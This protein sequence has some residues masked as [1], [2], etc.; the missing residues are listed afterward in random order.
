MA[1]L[2]QWKRTQRWLARI[3]HQP[4]RDEWEYDDF[5]WAFFQN[6][7]H[8]RDWIK[9]DSAIPAELKTNLAG[10]IRGYVSLKTCSDVAN[11]AKHFALDRPRDGTGAQPSHRALSVVAGDP[12]ETKL[13]I[14][15]TRG[16]GERID[17]LSLAREAMDAWRGILKKYGVSPP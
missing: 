15:I 3:E 9:Y 14:Y 4:P 7:W 5:V 11:G 12:E 1:Y 6:C 13:T 10:E 2:I 16:N 8:L 17:A